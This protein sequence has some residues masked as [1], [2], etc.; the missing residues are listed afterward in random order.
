MDADP[1]EDVET[2]SYSGY[3][4]KSDWR[5]WR[6]QLR[7]HAYD[8]LHTLVRADRESPTPPLDADTVPRVVEVDRE[9]WDD[10][11]STIPQ[12]ERVD[13]R[14]TELIERDCRAHRRD[15][16]DM[17]QATARV[18]AQRLRIRATQARGKLR[19]DSDVDAAMDILDEIVD[20]AE[21]LQD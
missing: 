12:T 5:P 2:V 4:P 17:E 16:A 3:M 20:L 1:F 11:L 18:I 7:G 21:T 8:R 19:D 9:T 6:A 14:V 15:S 10:W 13:E